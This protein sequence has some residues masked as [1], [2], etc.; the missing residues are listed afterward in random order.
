MNRSR[1]FFVLM[2]INVCVVVISGKSM[3]KMYWLDLFEC[4]CVIIDNNDWFY[5]CTIQGIQ[6]SPDVSCNTSAIRGNC[7]RFLEDG[8]GK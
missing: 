1:N 5:I 6:A 3:F 8:V 2:C 4:F 7:G